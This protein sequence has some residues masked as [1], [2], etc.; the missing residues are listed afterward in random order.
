MLAVVAFIGVLLAAATP[1]W[2]E[3][4]RERRV[5]N[6]ATSIANL[7]RVARSRAMGRG[8]A[9][10]V[11]WDKNA[12]QPTAADPQ[13]HFRV[14]EAVIGSGSGLSGNAN[15]LPSA[16][17]FSP[18]WSGDTTSKHVMVFDERQK[19]FEPAEATFLDQD[20][21]EQTVAEICFSP[22]GRT[23]VRFSKAGTFSVL[24][25][26]P[27]VR[28]RNVDSKLSRFVVFPP[29]GSARVVGEL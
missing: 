4:W 27:R 16:S 24:T 9:V 1:T 29:H 14:R 5:E 20:G 7:Y 19:Q 8:S 25:G 10:L 6:A 22:R 21:N 11:R 13:G 15:T 28:V 2:V 17:C 3:I 23:Y 26:V 18:D 12:A